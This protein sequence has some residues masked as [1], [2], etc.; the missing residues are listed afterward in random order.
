MSLNR[1]HVIKVAA[2]FFIILAASA[3]VY[4]GNDAYQMV[5]R[6]QIHIPIEEATNYAAS[7]MNQNESIMVVCA[8]NFYNRDMVKFY[9]QANEFRQNQVFQYPE[10]PV[11]AFKPNFNVNELISLCKEHNVKYVFLYE[12]GATFSYFNSTLTLHEVY[13]DLL[14]SGRFTYETIFGTSPRTISILSFA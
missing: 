1:K 3:V 9:L 4:S 7:H 12:Y 6:D 5:A 13:M 14:D 8:T 10:L 11:D 2:G